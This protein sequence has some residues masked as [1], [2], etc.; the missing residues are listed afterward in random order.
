MRFCA[1]LF[2]G[3]TLT[4]ACGSSAQGVRVLA[5][6]SDGTP[7]IKD[8]RA[9]LRS[10]ISQRS[11]HRRP[12]PRRG[13]ASRRRRSEAGAPRGRRL[14]RRARAPPSTTSRRTTASATGCGRLH[15]DA[16][17]VT[18]RASVPN[19][20]IAEA[21]AANPTSSSRSRRSIPTRAARGGGGAAAHRDHGVRGFK[22]HPNVQAFYPNDRAFYPLYEVVAERVCRRSSTRATRA[23][24]RVFQGEAESVSSTPT[25]CWTTSPSTFRS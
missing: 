1:P 25:R 20:E 21:A 5:E 9:E 16:E 7:V 2:P 23:S 3:D 14:L 11:K 22:F 17:T 6:G 19:E 15:V 12:C 13:W 8:G 24:A 10:S 4:P 18:G